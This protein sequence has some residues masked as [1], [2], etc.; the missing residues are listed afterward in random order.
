MTRSSRGDRAFFG[1]WLRD[2]RMKWRWKSSPS[3]EDGGGAQGRSNCEGSRCHVSSTNDWLL[4]RWNAWRLYLCAWHYISA[5]R[6]GP[7]IA[8]DESDEPVRVTLPSNVDDATHVSDA[9]HI[10]LDDDFRIFDEG[11]ES[12]RKSNYNVV[13]TSRRSLIVGKLIFSRRECVFVQRVLTKKSDARWTSKIKHFSRDLP[14]IIDS[15][16][17]W[18]IK[19]RYIE[20]NRDAIINAEERERDVLHLLKL[21]YFK[22]S[23]TSI[24]I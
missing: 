24:Y 5:T 2:P 17:G 23:I 19:C 15:I 8:R 7:V 6:E 16:S 9:R 10:L 14:T 22:N 4:H 1:R 3:H 13:F 21:I 12:P 20:A 11:R 18:E